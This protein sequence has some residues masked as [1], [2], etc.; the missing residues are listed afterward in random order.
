MPAAIA[1]FID[2]RPAAPEISRGV[3]LRQK[4]RN[5]YLIRQMF[6]DARNELVFNPRGEP[7][8]RTIEA[9]CLFPGP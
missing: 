4:P 5:G 3:I 7:H 9:R 1:Y 6:L 8:G 2:E